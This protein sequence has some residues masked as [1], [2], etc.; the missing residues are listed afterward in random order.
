MAMALQLALQPL[1]KTSSASLKVA[2]AL[3]QLLFPLRYM[4]KMLVH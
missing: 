3:G 1:V 2:P 4:D